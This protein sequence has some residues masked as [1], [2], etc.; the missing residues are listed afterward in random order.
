[1]AQASRSRLRARVVVLSRWFSSWPE[2]DGYFRALHEDADLPFAICSGANCELRRSTRA[3]WASS[4]SRW[5]VEWITRRISFR[6]FSSRGDLSL[7]ANRAAAI[8][9]LSSWEIAIGSPAI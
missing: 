3:K 1:M 5:R 4:D 9:L 6:S 7:A 2:A 8:S